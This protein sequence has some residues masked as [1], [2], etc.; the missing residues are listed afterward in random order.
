MLRYRSDL[1]NTGWEK[2][3]RS[4]IIERLYIDV[5]HDVKKN[6]KIRAEKAINDQCKYIQ[7]SL[8]A[9]RIFPVLMLV[10]AQ[11]ISFR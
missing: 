7:Y 4:V 3:V 9:D 6:E 2:G 10:F 8:C 11:K 5:R 1:G